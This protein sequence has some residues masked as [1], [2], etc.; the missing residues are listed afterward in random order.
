MRN[1]I[2]GGVLLTATCC[3]TQA[4]IIFTLGNN[5][6]NNEANILLNSGASATTV[7]ASPDGLPG[8]Y[9]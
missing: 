5:P 6:S 9:S 8:H 1:F 4:S 3:V 7:T 2:A